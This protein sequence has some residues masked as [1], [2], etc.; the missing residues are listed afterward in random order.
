MASWHHQSKRFSFNTGRQLFY[1]FW[2]DKLQT[3]SSTLDSFLVRAIIG[4]STNL[5][6]VHYY[7]CVLKLVPRYPGEAGYV[8]AESIT[9]PWVVNKKDLPPEEVESL[10][11]SVK[12]KYGKQS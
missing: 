6:R 11:T 2:G 8:D 1:L 4:T 3:I 5:S 7:C 12:E 9:F 10:E